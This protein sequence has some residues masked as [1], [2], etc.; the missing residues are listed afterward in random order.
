[1]SPISQETEL[2]DTL[3]KCEEVVVDLLHRACRTLSSPA[4]FSG[5]LA[6]LVPIP[7]TSSRPLDSQ[8]LIR[9]QKRSRHHSRCGALLTCRRQRCRNLSTRFPLSVVHRTVRLSQHTP[10]RSKHTTSSGIRVLSLRICMP[11][12]SSLSGPERAPC[13]NFAGRGCRSS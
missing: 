11:T 8:N 5:P 12:I 2:L 6:T 13:W 10:C 1:M 7:I 9:A 3:S 4:T